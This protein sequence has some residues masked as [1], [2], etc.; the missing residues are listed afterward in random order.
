MHIL[1]RDNAETIAGCLDSVRGV[2][3]RVLVADMGSKDG[4]REIARG[5]GADVISVVFDGDFSAI[6]NRI[7]SDGRNMYLEPWER[8][9]KGSGLIRGLS[10]N[11]SFYV[12]AG[13]VVSKQVRLWEGGRFENPVF[14]SVSGVEAQVTPEVAII[15]GRQPSDRASTLEA[16]R[17]WASRRPTS[18]DPY[19]Y[20]ACSL[21][22]EGKGREFVA[23][24]RK[25]LSLAVDGGDSVVL[26]N[27]YLARQEFAAGEAREAYRRAVG[28]LFSNPSFA[29]FWC[30]LGDMFCS[31]GEYRRAIHMYE[32]ARV[33]GAR[34]KVDDSFPIEISKYESYPS[35][36]EEKCRSAMSGGLVV[37]TK[38]A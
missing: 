38:R 14:E 25:Y 13:G 24:A 28:C 31:R 4:T 11:R 19:Y 12:L 37:P 26:M 23:A 10:G 21:L 7:C 30:L 3:D 16:C 2:C 17:I 5:R 22:S 9:A 1:T 32:N 36:M 20:L 6:R 18:P 8:V 35:L 34:R 33:C 15:S 27:Y 29:E